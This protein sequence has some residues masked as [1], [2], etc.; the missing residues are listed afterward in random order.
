[1]TPEK[2]VQNNIVD[3]M[4][5]LSELNQP[6]IY[7]RRQAGGFNY[8]KGIP[9]L[10]ASIDGKHV[11]IEVKAPGK[12]L[13]TMQEKY[14]DKCKRNNV[15]WICCDNIEDFKEFIYQKLNIKI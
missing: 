12:S 8:K 6:I 13:R 3:Y 2:I 15:L 14:R 7:D 10:W 9:D 5:K 1:M 4:K 11:E